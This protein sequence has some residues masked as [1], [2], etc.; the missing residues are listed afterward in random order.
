MDVVYPL[1]YKTAPDCTKFGFC[2]HKR[3]TY[4]ELQECICAP[5]LGCCVIIHSNKVK[6]SNK[7][8]YKALPLAYLSNVANCKEQPRVHS[9][10]L[11]LA[12][13]S[14][15][16][17]ILLE[18]YLLPSPYSGMRVSR[19]H[20]PERVNFWIREATWRSGEGGGAVVSVSV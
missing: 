13:S 5:C 9:Y 14:R 7:A 6:Y 18:S 11:D 3:T 16:P 20:V 8:K 2:L 12:F 1:K 10:R 19:F 17:L 15:P 4:E